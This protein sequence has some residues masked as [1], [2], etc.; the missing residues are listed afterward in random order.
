MG[1]KGGM[2]RLQSRKVRVRV[3]EY[4]RSKRTEIERNQS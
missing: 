3:S 4:V 1:P 2:E